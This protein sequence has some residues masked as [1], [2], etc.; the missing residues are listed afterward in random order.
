MAADSN[1]M[2]AW[3]R[4]QVAR[5]RETLRRLETANFAYGEIARA[6][7]G[8]QPRQ[9]IVEV[10]R[11]IRE[12]QEII[13]THDRQTRRPLTTDHHTLA[14]ARWSNWNAHGRSNAG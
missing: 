14:S 3:H 11:K 12:S 5:L 4:A 9:S 8:D 13:T 6:K 2:I 7:S 10:K 1:S